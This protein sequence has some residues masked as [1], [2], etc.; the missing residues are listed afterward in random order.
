MVRALQYEPGF[1]EVQFRSHQI[2]FCYAFVSRKD[3]KELS[4]SQFSKEFECRRVRIKAKLANG[5]EEPKVRGCHFALDENLAGEILAWTET[6]AEKYT[7]ITNRD[8]RH[9]YKVKYSD[10]VRRG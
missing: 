3:D 2:Y 7:P 4:M 6:Q 9:H 10:S 8:L 1:E 5:L